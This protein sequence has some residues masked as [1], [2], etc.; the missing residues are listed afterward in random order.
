MVDTEGDTIETAVAGFRDFAGD[1]RLVSFN[2]DFDMAFLE[3]AAHGIGWKLTNPVS[4]ALKMARRAWPGRKSYRLADLSKD[5]N[6]D[7]AESHRALDDA[8]RTVV[9]YATAAKI[10][11]PVE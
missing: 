5:G 6:L 7:L 4:C 1:L 10:L 9:I 3:N 2:A 8:T 11:N